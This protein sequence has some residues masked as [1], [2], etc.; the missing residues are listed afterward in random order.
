M[1]EFYFNPDITYLNHGSFGATPKSVL[2]KQFEWQRKMEEQP[3]HFMERVLPE[4]LHEAK[5]VAARF[6]DCD[7]NDLFFVRNATTGINTIL[8][9]LQLKPGEEIL[10]TNHRYEAVGQTV[11]SFAKRWGA[12]VKEAHI[13]FPAPSREEMTES[14]LD[15]VSA[16][17]RIV[18]VDQISSLTAT[19]FPVDALA[20]AFREKN[21]LFIVDG[22]HAPG[23]ISVSL[24]SS[25]FDFWTGNLHKWCCAPKGSALLYVAPQHQRNFHASVVSHGYSQG[26]HKEFEWMGTEDYSA[27]LASS[28]AIL[29]HESWGGAELREKNFRLMVEATQLLLS[30]VPTLRTGCSERTLAMRSFLWEQQQPQQIYANLLKN[31]KIEI[32]LQP[33]GNGSILRVSTFTP[34]NTINQIRLLCDALRQESL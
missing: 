1:S 8:D 34:Y 10:V 28:D 2:E 32:V 14:I 7:P 33:W 5:C 30:E 19:L 3:V 27:Y 29:L 12:A 4:A 23:Q 15:A 18:L 21:I 16:K 17:T 25:G 11:K 31:R 20:D 6:L 9:N 24:D 13:D 26:I 22:A